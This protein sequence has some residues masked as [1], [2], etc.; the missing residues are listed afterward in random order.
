MK[1]ISWLLVDL[2]FDHVS[3]YFMHWECPMCL[4][5]EIVVLL[6]V[7]KCYILAV[8]DCFI[9]LSTILVFVCKSHV[10][11]AEFQ[12]IDG[13]ARG[14]TGFNFN[15]TSHASTLPTGHC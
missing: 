6:G 13:S 10:V 2:N 1:T 11:L 7:Y 12:H 8:G 3:A 15:H 14:L 5:S 9:D 4:L